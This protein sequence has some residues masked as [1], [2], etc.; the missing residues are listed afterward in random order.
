MKTFSMQAVSSV[1]IQRQSVVGIPVYHDQDLQD[2]LPT[3]LQEYQDHLCAVAEQKKFTGS[4]GSTCSTNLFVGGR[5]VTVML[6]GVG[7]N[8]T[9]CVEQMRRAAGRLVK[10]GRTIA[11]AVMALYTVTDDGHML[12]Q[13]AIAAQMA[14]YKFDDCFTKDDAKNKPC[15]FELVSQLTDVAQR[16]VQKAQI[17]AGAVNDARRWVDMPPSDLTPTIVA[18]Y[19]QEYA[20][21]YGMKCTIF[22]EKAMRE[23]NMGGIL[24]VSAGSAQEARLV[25]MEYKCSSPDAPTVALV[26][27]GITFDSGGLSLKPARFMETMK[28]DMAGAA[29]VIHAITALAQLKPDVNV[30]ACAALSENLPGEKATKPGDVLRFYNGMTAEILNTDAEGRLVLAD[31]LAYISDV[32]KPDV[33]MDV[34]TLTGACD[35]AV[36]P[37]FTA[38]MGNDKQ[39]VGAVKKAGDTVGDP[40]WEL[41]FTADY[42]TVMKSKIADLANICTN[43]RM[44][45][46][47]VTAGVF[48]ENFVGDTKWFHLDI[49]STAF[50]VPVLPY[51]DA[52]ATGSSIRLMIEFAQTYTK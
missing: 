22:D 33:M 5:V 30:I 45:A 17:I 15:S 26:G 28:E 36:G 50:D 43:G 49:A 16:A 32:Y 34:A 8:D 31:A 21:T 47:T 6:L 29:S 19:A 4:A 23:K 44:K 1:D 3:A 9:G 10:Y 13:I 38:I 39:V 12:E 51:F 46:G 24:G 40:V 41:P 14:Y 52:G 42:K 11:G 25:V 18:N 27:K 37:F 2:A 48:L 35:Y 7:K 20:D